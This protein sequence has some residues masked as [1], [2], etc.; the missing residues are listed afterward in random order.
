MDVLVTLQ[1]AAATYEE[2]MGIARRWTP[3]SPEWKE[4]D[5]SDAELKYSAAVN[6]LEGLVI[7]RVFELSK[8]NRSGT[9]AYFI[10]RPLRGS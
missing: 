4:A 3:E 8:M 2:K 7:A 9:C 10:Y 1:E 5:Q 6:R